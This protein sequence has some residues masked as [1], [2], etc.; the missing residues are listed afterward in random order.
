MFLHADERPGP[1][2]DGYPEDFR[3]RDQVLRAHGLDGTIIGGRVVR[4]GTDRVA[5]AAELLTDPG[6][7]FVQTRNVVHGCYVLTLT[8][9]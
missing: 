9:R 5:E 1:A 2:V 4:A 3:A 7:D 6:V 8:H